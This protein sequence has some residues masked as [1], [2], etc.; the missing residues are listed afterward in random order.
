[1]KKLLALSAIACSVLAPSVMAAEEVNVYSYRQPFLIEPMFKEF[2]QE[3]GIKVN[4]KFAKEGIAEKLA[5]E[6]EYSPAD[7]ILTSEFSRLF[8]L[9]D[10]GLT[11]PVNS[12]VIDENIPAQYRDSSEEWFALTVRTRS[13]Y[14][15]R[16]RV[17]KLGD[18]FDY[19]DLAKPEYKGKI[20]TRSG[21][22]PYNIALVAAMIANH[23]EAQTKTWL[24]GLKANLAR[25]PQGNDRDQVRAIK[26]GLCDLSL[27]NSYYLGK[28]LEDK[29]QKSW[30][31]S[32]Y[33]NFPG[34]NVQ[35]THVNV[36]GMAMA[37]YAPNRDNAVKLM[38]F[39][40]GETA[41]HMYAEVNYEYPVKPGV[42]RSKL[43]ASWGEFKS[44]SL[45]LEKIADNHAAAIKL[46]DEVK[47]DL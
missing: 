38:E 7:V 29:E 43:V 35:G 9:S 42:E 31:E 32:V 21:K 34:Q 3:T 12:R 8:E 24:E 6:G 40:T 25:K 37:K 4:V 18:D 33:I 5:Q 17:G 20:C 46:L 23:G 30:A 11:Q 22:H 45:P 39:L 16:D 26:E 2:T 1:M 10:K 28:M 27:G 47:F 15:S 14:S 41:Q 19:L 36:S 44:D 13:V